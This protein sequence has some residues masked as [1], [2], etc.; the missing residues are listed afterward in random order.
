M[1]VGVE[2]ELLHVPAAVLFVSPELAA[3]S[4]RVWLSA[5]TLSSAIAP[6][7]VLASATVSPEIAPTSAVFAAEELVSA[8]ASA[9]GT[10]CDYNAFG[11][12]QRRQ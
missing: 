9:T 2:S 8:L 12:T 11:Q 7:F 10:L 3:E 1:L 6:E 5:L 4:P